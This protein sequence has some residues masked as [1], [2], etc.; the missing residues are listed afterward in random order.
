M[1]V[2]RTSRVLIIGAHG[3][4][5]ALTVHA[6]RGAGWQVRGAA[7]KPRRGEVHVDLDRPDSIAAALDERELVVNTVPH[8]GL[9]AERLVLE[10]GGTLVNV[11]AL[12][13][14]AGRSLRAVAGGARGT[15]LMNAGLAPGVTTIVA[16][17][18]LRAHPEADELEIV[19]TLSS[20]APRGRAS[21]DFLH[22]GLSAVTRHRTAMIPLPRPFGERRCLGFGEGDAGWLGG[23]AEG[24]VVRQYICITEPV[25]HERLL[26]LN[27]AGAMKRLP[28]SLVGSR[29]SIDGSAGSEPVAHWIAVM[30]AG[31]R[32][33]ARTVECRGDFVHAAHSTVVFAE[34]LL[35]RELRGGCFDPEEVGAVEDVRQRLQAGGVRIVSH[36]AGDPSPQTKGA[37]RWRSSAA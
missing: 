8:P 3:V 29:H 1:D 19:F 2:R 6:F 20:T 27:G 24:R 5:G 12:P 10:R 4:L 25:A 36:P 32:L 18:L 16:A 23:I 26:G 13:A 37:A 28:R 35:E 34:V 9:P 30:R 11:S 7:R 17:D 22:R 14:A 15:V 21:A 31:R 33:G